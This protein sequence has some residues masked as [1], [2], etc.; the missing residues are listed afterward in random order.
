VNEDNS[1][2]ILLQSMLH[3]KRKGWRGFIEK[4]PA[5]TVP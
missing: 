2:G 1:L 4:N 3:G 5:S